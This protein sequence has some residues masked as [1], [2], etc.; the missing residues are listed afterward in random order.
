VLGVIVLYL[1][2][3]HQKTER[4]LTF[5]QTIA[6]TL[7]G[8]IELK[9]AE[10]SLAQAH[11]QALEASRLK[12]QL[13]AN[14]SHVL[15]TPL[16]SIL[17]YTE[18][19]QAGVYEP[20]TGQQQEAITE[21]IESAEQLLNFINNLLSQAQIETGKV[22]LNAVSFA[23]AELLDAIQST[24][25]AL[26]RTKGLEL[27]SAIAPDMPAALSGDPYWL[28][29]IIINLVSNAIKFT[30]R[31]AVGVHIYRADDVHWAIQVTDT[32]CGIPAEAQTYIFDSFRQV[33]E[34]AI[35]KQ[36]T[37]SGLGLSIVKQLTDLMGGQITLTSQE[38]QGSTFTVLLPLH[39]A[40]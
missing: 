28:R 19:L 33:D 38:G 20:L 26:A 35:R 23:P 32:G 9:R 34:T 27:T 31:G 15:R 8:I 13:L 2:A 39:S 17:G 24:S 7:A 5:L 1:P 29:Q 18:M 11:D 3:G 40:N 6:N 36:H 14:I 37:G 21:I 4:D 25:R 22:V 12:S 30:D 16:G 10:E